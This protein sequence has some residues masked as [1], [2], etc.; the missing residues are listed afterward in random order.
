M[1]GYHVAGDSVPLTTILSTNVALALPTDV[2]SNAVPWVVIHHDSSGG[3]WVRLGLVGDTI[4]GI[5]EGIFVARNSGG[6]AF[7]VGASTHVHCFD[8]VSDNIVSITPLGQ[9][10]I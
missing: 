3:A 4:S 2:D 8:L 10:P 9:R 1:P 5:G 6:E 7:Y